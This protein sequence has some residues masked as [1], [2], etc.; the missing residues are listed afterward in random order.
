M[1]YFY[2]TEFL[3]DGHTIDLVSVGVVAE[4]GREFYAVSTEFDPSV[5]NQWVRENVLP[6]LPPADDPAWRSR[7]QIRE[8]LFRFLTGGEDVGRRERLRPQLWAWVG[9][10]DHV[11]W[12][13][14]GET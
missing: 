12:P 14:S 5:A 11:R 7:R 2:D 4:D 13:S 1:R 3:E 6:Q 8:E 9:A 10:Y